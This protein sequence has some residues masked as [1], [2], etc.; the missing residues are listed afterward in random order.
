[1]T[2]PT[3]T[4]HQRLLPAPATLFTVH[5]TLSCDRHS[6]AAKCFRTACPTSIRW[7]SSQ[8]DR[9]VE[10]A[11]N[12]L[13]PVGRSPP[14]QIS[15]FRSHGTRCSPISGRSASQNCRRNFSPRSVYH[16]QACD[17]PP[18]LNPAL[19]HDHLPSF[20]PRCR[21]PRTASIGLR[22]PKPP[23][24][25]TCVEIIVVLTSWWPSSSW[26]MRMSYPSSA[27][28]WRSCASAQGNS[29]A[30]TAPLPA[31]PP[32]RPAEAPSR[33]GGAVASGRSAHTRLQSMAL[34]NATASAHVTA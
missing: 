27:N 6:R 25:S 32:A 18:I 8:S 3:R 5:S 4:A 34:A 13:R 30:S 20:L 9:P 22:T 12:H 31:R 24:L 29:L 28:A 26:I 17:R 23:R 19:S 11:P 16:P 14:P 15:L 7:Q 10:L 21:P 1:M 33:A 2:T